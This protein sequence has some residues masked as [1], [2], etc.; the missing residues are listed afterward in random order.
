MLAALTGASCNWCVLQVATPMFRVHAL[1]FVHAGRS[2][3]NIKQDLQASSA[4]RCP[5]EVV[6]IALPSVAQ[7][8]LLVTRIELL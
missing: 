2:C 7:L 4:E 3:R 8:L 5:N 6:Q 1:T